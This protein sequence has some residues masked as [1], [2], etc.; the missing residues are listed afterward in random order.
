[1]SSPWPCTGP[2]VQASRLC[3]FTFQVE[4]A[5]VNIFMLCALVTYDMSIKS[6]PRPTPPRCKSTVTGTHNYVGARRTGFLLAPV[7]NMFNFSAKFLS[8]WQCLA[9]GAITVD[10]ILMQISVKSC[11]FLAR[12]SAEVSLWNALSSPHLSLSCENL[13]LASPHSTC[14]R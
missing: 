13:P 2:A 6:A 7:S 8:G 9:P 14:Q 3:L 1:M 12:S 5:F 10:F 4:T 11:P